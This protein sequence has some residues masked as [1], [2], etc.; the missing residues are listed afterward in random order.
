MQGMAESEFIVLAS[1]SP[2]RRRMFEDLGVHFVVRPS[3]IDE[4]VLPGEEPAVFAKRAA[5]E[6]A[7]DVSGKIWREENQRP[8]I[9][10]ADTVV[11]L[12]GDI[13]FKPKDEDDAVGMLARLSGRTHTVITGWAA[14]RHDG[15]WEI[16]CAETQVTFHELTGEE[17]R[18]Y[19]R[20]GEG[21]DKA[22]AYAIQGLGTYLVDRIEGN[23]FNVVGLPISHVVRALKGL[24]AL[25][26]FFAP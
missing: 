4:V 7:A 18:G 9:V 12:D 21:L 26:G 2:R 5:A 15:P 6:K 24:G 11:V 16:A 25:G 1:A 14:G 13:L 3:G 23:Y 17:I 10:G 19:A 22:G 8:W 20:T